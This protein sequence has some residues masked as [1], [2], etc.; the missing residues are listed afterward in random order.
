MSSTESKRF[1]GPWMGMAEE[2]T[3]VPEKLSF[4]EI[5]AV[6][7]EYRGGM[8]IDV[9]RRVKRNLSFILTFPESFGDN[10]PPLLFNRY[11]YIDRKRKPQ[12]PPCGGK[13]H[14]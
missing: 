2:I 10:S 3:G 1:S 4:E 6:V 8:M 11:I 7:V 12:A 5:I 13:P 14:L 9:V